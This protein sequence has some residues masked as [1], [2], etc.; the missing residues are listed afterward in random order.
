MKAGRVFMPKDITKQMSQNGLVL[1]NGLYVGYGFCGGRFESGNWP[2]GHGAYL[3][4]RLVGMV[5]IT[6]GKDGGPCI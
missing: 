3:T 4:A 2:S 6:A 1:T 5:N